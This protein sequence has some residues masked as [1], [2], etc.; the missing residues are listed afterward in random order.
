M[1]ILSQKFQCLVICK[2][3]VNGCDR[4]ITIPYSMDV[5]IFFMHTME[6]APTKPVVPLPSRVMYLLTS[7]VI[8]YLPLTCKF[9]PGDFILIS[10]RH[11][12]IQKG[13]RWKSLIENNS[14]DPGGKGRSSFE[15]ERL[16]LVSAHKRNGKRWN[17][18]Y[19]TFY[20][21]GNSS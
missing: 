6:L 7:I 20:R 8:D 12:D 14:P 1:I 13:V 18:E 15:M 16:R 19:G 17:A 21:T 2:I 10:I 9:N 11:I 5:R 4:D 3:K